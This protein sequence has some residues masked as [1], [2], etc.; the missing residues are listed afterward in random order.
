MVMNEIC[1]HVFLAILLLLLILYV[2]TNK[3]YVVKAH[4]YIEL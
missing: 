1:G 4:F 2:L 3:F